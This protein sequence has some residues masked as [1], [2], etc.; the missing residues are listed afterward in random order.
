MIYRLAF[1]ALEKDFLNVIDETTIH[2]VQQ[3]LHVENG[4]SDDEVRLNSNDRKIIV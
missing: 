4:L 2:E 1:A 3:Q